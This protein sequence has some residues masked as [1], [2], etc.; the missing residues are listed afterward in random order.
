[1]KVKVLKKFIDQTDYS[2][3]E[4]GAVFECPRER[5]KS[6]ITKKFVEEVS[7]EQSEEEKPRKSTKKAASKKKK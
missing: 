1:M 6:L 2:V 7:N 5:A 3:K 4:V